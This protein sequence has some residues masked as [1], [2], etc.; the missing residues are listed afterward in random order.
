MADF[1][2]RMDYL[3]NGGFS[4]FSQMKKSEWDLCFAPS[5]E[6]NPRWIK[7]S[8]RKVKAI[9]FLEDNVEEYFYDFGEGKDFVNKGGGANQW[10]MNNL[11]TV[12]VL[13][14][15]EHSTEW[16][17]KPKVEYDRDIHNISNL[18]KSYLQIS[19]KKKRNVQ[20]CKYFTE[21]TEMAHNPEKMAN[22]ISH[23]EMHL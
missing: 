3:I 1:E 12:I 6:S 2:G 5:T 21:G 18:L 9:K 13:L 10:K 20:R 19:N 8:H 16:K 14:F 7:G 15:T 4:S 11:A 23:Q 17:N 22:L